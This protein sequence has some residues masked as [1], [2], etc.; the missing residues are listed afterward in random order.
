VESGQSVLFEWG[1]KRLHVGKATQV[2]F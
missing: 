1:T 2:V